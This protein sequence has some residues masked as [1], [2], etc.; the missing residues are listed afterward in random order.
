MTDAV[1]PEVITT[2]RLILRPFRFDDVD[3]VFAYA[4]DSEWSRFLRILPRP[5][6]REHARQFIARQ[7]LRDRATH[8]SWAMTMEGVVVGGVNLRIDVAQRSA[9]LGYSVARTHWKRGLC[10]EAARAVID[11]AFGARPD[12]V[13]VHARADADNLGSQRVMEKIGMVKEGVLR[14]S[15]VERGEVFDEARFSILRREWEA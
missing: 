3:D 2:E 11:A 6:E 8:P 4:R 10:T 14:S 5:Y 12:L 13:R 7:I 9:E 1:L 15:R